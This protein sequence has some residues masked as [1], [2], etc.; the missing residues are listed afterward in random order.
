MEK[1]A[2]ALVATGALLAWAYYAPRVVATARQ[3][4]NSKAA[5]N[6]R[7]SRAAN[8]EFDRVMRNLA[9]TDPTWTARVR[10]ASRTARWAGSRNRNRDVSKFNF[11]G[12]VR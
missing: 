6:R 4:L 12:P 3:V 2:L 10:H 11:G 8:R 5:A 9:A 7:A 1:V